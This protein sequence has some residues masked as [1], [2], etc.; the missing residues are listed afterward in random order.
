MKKIFL[1]LLVSLFA[2]QSDDDKP[3]TPPKTIKVSIEPKTTA[4]QRALIGCFEVK[5]VDDYRSG[6]LRLEKTT[7]DCSI[8]QKDR[9]LLECYFSEYVNIEYDGLLIPKM[10]LRVTRNKYVNPKINHT[11][12]I[13]L[14]FENAG[15]YARKTASDFYRY[16]LHLNDR[17]G[18]EERNNVEVSYDEDEQTVEAPEMNVKR[19]TIIVVLQELLAENHFYGAQMGF[20][21]DVRSDVKGTAKFYSVD[22]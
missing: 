10:E 22:E 9:G 8:K 15:Q 14:K 4:S 21:D 19:G 13:F 3:F 16:A 17:S 12:I 7:A 1:L 6:E 11:H 2:C 5:N 20:F 18:V